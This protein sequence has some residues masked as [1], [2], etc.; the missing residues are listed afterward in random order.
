M[1]YIVYRCDVSQEK[2]TPQTQAVR[3]RAVVLSDKMNVMDEINLTCSLLGDVVPSPVSLDK[4]YVDIKSIDESTLSLD[5]MQQEVREWLSYQLAK[6]RGRM[7]F[8]P[9]RG[10]NSIDHDALPLVVGDGGVEEFS[11]SDI[12][13]SKTGLFDV[14]DLAKK[15]LGKSFSPANDDGYPSDCLA[16]R[17]LV[18][19][20]NYLPFYLQKELPGDV[21]LPAFHGA[22]ETIKLASKFNVS[23]LKEF[24]AQEFYLNDVSLMADEKNISKGV[25]VHA[26][27]KRDEGP[28][29]YYVFDVLQF[30]GEEYAVMTSIEDRFA[31]NKSRRSQKLLRQD[32]RQG[33]GM[34]KVVRI[35][36][37][38]TQAIIDQRFLKKD[39]KATFKALVSDIERRP[40]MVAKVLRAVKGY[41]KSRDD[42]KVLFN[43][44]AEDGAQDETD[45]VTFRSESFNKAAL[46]SGLMRGDDNYIGFNE[47]ET[48][49]T[50]FVS[51]NYRTQW[52]NYFNRRKKQLRP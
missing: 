19:P 28:V 33:K 4:S 21:I 22:V 27:E 8:V 46:Y 14:K 31:K 51:G 48:E 34:F 13:C 1:P 35:C 10:V 24:S 5:E 20:K 29:P 32:I 12:N 52:M 36:D 40:L 39:E 18:L 44:Y 3:F 43:E 17:N 2:I 26:Q 30:G 38:P 37:I 6:R 11:L 15:I 45:I 23:L 7:V 49:A 47:A 9:G 25:L 50:S 41:L 42:F 16:I